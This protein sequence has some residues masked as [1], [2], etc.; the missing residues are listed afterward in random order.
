MDVANQKF[1]LR[2][3]NLLSA[4][5]LVLVAACSSSTSAFDNGTGTGGDNNVTGT[6][7]TGNSGIRVTGA[8]GIDTTSGGVG[9]MS[10]TGNSGTPV[11][12]AGGISSGVGGMNTT[13]TAC[14]SPTGTDAGGVTGTDGG[15]ANVSPTCPAG[16]G[17]KGICHEFYAADNARNQINYVNQFTSTSPGGIVWTAKVGDTGANS[18]RTMEIVD[19]AR[20]K[21]GKAVLVSV[22]KGFEEFDVV[23]GT[24]IASVLTQTG[25]TVTGACRLPDGTTALGMVDIIKIVSPVG[26]MVG[27]FNLPAGGELRAIN[28][29]PADGH[30][31]FSKTETVYETDD[32]GAQLWK[33]Y[34]GVGTKGYAVWWREGGGAFGTTGEPASIVELDAAGTIVTTTGGQTVFPFLDFLDGFVRLP[35]GNYVVGNWLGHLATPSPDA[36][37]IVEFA[38]P[39][40][41]NAQG[42]GVLGPCAAPRNEV[43][44]QW[45]CPTCPQGNQ[46][47]SRCIT[48]VLVLR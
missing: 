48:N 44:W 28:R 8:G 2:S 21:C 34:M 1:L 23:D 35:N 17:Y 31:W 6:S 12:G 33:G 38:A 16:H 26:A 18:P 42:A 27:Q 5:T 19:D 25:G 37:Q 4:A 15:D 11:T 46:T 20:A 45:E 41:V 29:N 30:F 3:G 10:G 39:C 32:Q 13:G 7:S 43:V 22:D 36:A 24:K 9:G 14:S 47:L 40:G